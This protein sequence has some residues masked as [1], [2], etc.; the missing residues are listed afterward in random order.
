[1]LVRMSVQINLQHVFKMSTFL[2]SRSEN[3]AVKERLKLVY[4]CESYCKNKS[5]TLLIIWLIDY[6]LSVCMMLII[7]YALYQGWWSLI[8]SISV[9]NFAYFYTFHCL[10]VFVFS[11]AGDLS[12]HRDFLSGLI[13]GMTV[14]L[15]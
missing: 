1:L 14:V 15:I 4:I 6:M 5:G 10:R 9:N 8:V 2:S 7:R 13:A 11:T 3:A 12:M